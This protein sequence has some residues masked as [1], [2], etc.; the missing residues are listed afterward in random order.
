MLIVNAGIFPK[1]FVNFVLN[2]FSISCKFEI[3]VRSRSSQQNSFPN[4][5]YKINVRES[6]TINSFVNFYTSE[7]VTLRFSY[8]SNLFLYFM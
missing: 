5:Y 3:P 4:S 8:S 2:I 1:R 7:S 6:L